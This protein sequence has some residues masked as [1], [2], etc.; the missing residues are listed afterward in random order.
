MDL[1]LE[2]KRHPGTRVSKRWW[3]QEVLDLVGMWT[4]YQEAELEEREGEAD[5]EETETDDYVGG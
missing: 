5:G 4:V 2:A 1:C 3:D